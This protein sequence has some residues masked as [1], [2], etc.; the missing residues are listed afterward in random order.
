MANNEAKT[1]KTNSLEEWRQNTNDTSHRLGDVEL[2]DGRLTDKVYS[3]NTVSYTHLTLPT[4]RE[5]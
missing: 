1:F 5:V 4:N 2:L 3:F